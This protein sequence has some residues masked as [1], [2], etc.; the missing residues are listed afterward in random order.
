MAK[1]L[2]NW[3]LEL[4]LADI[5]IKTSLL[6]AH[7]CSVNT[8]DRVF[9]YKISTN[10]LPT[11]EYLA[12][13]RITDTELCDHCLHETD[14]IIHRLYECEWVAGIVDR[15][16]KYIKDNCNKLYTPNMVEYI[17]GKTGIE[18][19]GL[20]HLLL[21]LKKVIFYSKKENL[22]SPHFFELFSNRIRNL[23]KKEKKIHSENNS[24]GDFLIKWKDFT[25]F[26][27]F[28]GPDDLFTCL[29]D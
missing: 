18:F 27:D 9:Q 29:S 12:R 7:K 4:E 11:N 19:L 14:T 8:F 5:Q 15:V 13:Y 10:I 20:N 24:F 23:I 22:S 17:F 25:V 16:L 26:Y 1:G 3:C 2:L 21:E 6:F 28:R